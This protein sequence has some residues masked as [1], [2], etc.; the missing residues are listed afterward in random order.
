MSLPP[1]DIQCKVVAI[2]SAYDDLIENNLRRIAILEETIRLL[3]HEWF[4]RLQ[5]P[6]GD[7]TVVDSES[8]PLPQGWAFRPF[9]ELLTHHIGGGWGMES[10]QGTHENAAYVIRG[11]DIP[12]AKDLFTDRIPLRYHTESNLKNRLLSPGSIVMEV[13]GGSTDQAVGRA[14]LVSKELLKSLGLPTICASFCKKLTINHEI[15]FP[16]LVWL[17]LESIYADGRIKEYEVQST[18]IKNFKFAVFLEKELVMV[19]D[20]AVQSRFL[21]TVRPMLDAIQNAGS[22]NRVLRGFRDLL[23]PRLVS[24][25]LDVADLIIDTERLTA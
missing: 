8:A 10:P 2:L 25:E 22:T 14:V 3:Y 21:D 7:R 5:F 16:E 1:L 11:T 13:S 23:L 17:H 18:G 4:V 15:I 9:G 19:P 6:K 12:R 20:R 24:G